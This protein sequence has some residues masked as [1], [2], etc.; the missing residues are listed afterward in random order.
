MIVRIA[1]IAR[2]IAIP[3]RIH[4]LTKSC[5]NRRTYAQSRMQIAIIVASFVGP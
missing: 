1:I 5:I 4:I 3:E 2:A